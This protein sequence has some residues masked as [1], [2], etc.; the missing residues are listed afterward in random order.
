MKLCSL[1]AFPHFEGNPVKLDHSA[2]ETLNS[3]FCQ[4]HGNKARQF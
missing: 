3:P 1:N 2:L 4:V